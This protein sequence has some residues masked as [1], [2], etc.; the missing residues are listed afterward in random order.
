[1]KITNF[2]RRLEFRVYAAPNRLKA[3]LQTE[4]YKPPCSR[5]NEEADFS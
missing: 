2:F 3:E 5:R 1:L 4:A